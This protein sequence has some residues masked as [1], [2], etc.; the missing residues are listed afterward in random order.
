MITCIWVRVPTSSK[1]HLFLPLESETLWGSEFTITTGIHTP[2][3][4]TWSKPV[5]LCATRWILLCMN[6]M[7]VCCPWFSERGLFNKLWSYS[8]FLEQLQ[9][10]GGLSWSDHCWKGRQL[11]LNRCCLAFLR[12][13]NV[14]AWRS[15]WEMHD[16]YWNGWISWCVSMSV[17]YCML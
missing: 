10:K 11:V 16:Y 8:V 14:F 6:V 17:C 4:T 7:N 15:I 2:Q 3:F 9:H 12:Y 13:N 5:L 1:M